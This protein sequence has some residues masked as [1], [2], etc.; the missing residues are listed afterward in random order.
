MKLFHM[1]ARK[2]GIKNKYAVREIK[3][4]AGNLLAAVLIKDKE[5]KQKEKINLF[6]N[7]RRL[8]GI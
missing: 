1:L 8:Q 7:W 6:E 3:D 5:L 2:L 4:S